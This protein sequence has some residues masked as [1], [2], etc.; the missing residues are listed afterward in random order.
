ML[1]ASASRAAK[2]V[3]LCCFVAEC[4]FVALTKE[5]RRCVIEGES[6]FNAGL[7]VCCGIKKVT[8]TVVNVE[9]LCLQTSAMKGPPHCVNVAVCKDTG[10]VKV[11]ASISSSTGSI[12]SFLDSHSEMMDAFNPTKRPKRQTR[13][14]KR[15]KAER[16]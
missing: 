3:R 9:S 11:S 10:S 12:N 6:T 13:R 8:D 5:T 14:P 7:I 15:E 4:C 1:Q 16:C 2:R